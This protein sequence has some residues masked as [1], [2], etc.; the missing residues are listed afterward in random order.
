MIKFRCIFAIRINWNL[1]RLI[2]LSALLSSP[3]IAENAV[4][5]NARLLSSDA[6]AQAAEAAERACRKKGFQVSAAVSDR[7]GNLLA[8][9]RNPLSGVHTIEVAQDKAYSAATL[10]TSTID[11]RVDLPNL[12]NGR[13]RILRV[14]G[15]VP[16]RVGGH[17]YGAVGVSGAPAEKRQGDND[18]VCARAGI[19]AIREKLEFGG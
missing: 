15:G 11:F 18:D 13:S 19:E 7:Y 9:K 6:A 5:V 4:Y 2:V 17:M 14:G 1:R 8:F 3:V 16:I 12:L 10:Q